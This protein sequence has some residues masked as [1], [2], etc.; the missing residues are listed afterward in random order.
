MHYNN[1][2]IFIRRLIW[3]NWNLGHIARHAVI[4]EEVEEVCHS[5]PLVLESYKER[6]LL[7]GSTLSGKMLAV[8]LDPEGEEYIT[9]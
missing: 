7:I 6:L 9:R 3:D 1:S 5:N 8:V 4:P 2:M